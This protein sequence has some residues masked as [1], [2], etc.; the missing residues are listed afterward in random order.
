M[1]EI[2][3]KD[4]TNSRT[5]VISCDGVKEGIL[6]VNDLV[7]KVPSIEGWNIVAF[8]QPVDD[9]LT[10]EM[11]GLKL[12][13][14]DILFDYQAAPDN[15]VD[16][17]LYVDKLSDTN[18]DKYLQ[19]TFVLLDAAIGEYAAMTKIR[20]IELLQIPKNTKT[21]RPLGELLKIVK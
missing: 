4:K 5:L 6:A 10:I 15:M 8:R 1:F 16:I 12:S 19:A 14:N 7:S 20:Y 9:N 11:D 21:L 3:Q 2:G 13:T 18:R 17:T